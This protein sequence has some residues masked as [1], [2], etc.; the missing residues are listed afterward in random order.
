MR[1][2]PPPRTPPLPSYVNPN[3]VSKHRRST[4]SRYLIITVAIL[5]IAVFLL[6]FLP[7][8]SENPSQD[9]DDDVVLDAPRGMRDP[10]PYESVKRLSRDDLDLTK[11]DSGRE[12]RIRDPTLFDPVKRFSRD[13]LDPSADLDELDFGRDRRGRRNH[14]DSRRRQ[15]RHMDEVVD[16]PS[17]GEATPL[18]DLAQL[19][20][21]RENEVG[22]LLVHWR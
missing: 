4:T 2:V 22:V 16:I 15:G 18:T 13:D 14:R 7:S 12:R 8:F 9:D 1:R 6:S 20:T 3:Y 17:I 11:R 10:T 5:M 19:D 21:V